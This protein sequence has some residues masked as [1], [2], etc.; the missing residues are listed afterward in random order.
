MFLGYVPILVCTCLSLTWTQVLYFYLARASPLGSSKEDN[1][2]AYRV[3]V[4]NMLYEDGTGRD[5]LLVSGLDSDKVLHPELRQLGDVVRDLHDYLLA[6]PWQKMEED[7]HFPGDLRLHPAHTAVVMRRILLAAMND[8]ALQDVLDIELC[9]THPRDPLIYRS[10]YYSNT[11]TDSSQS[12]SQSSS[13]NYSIASHTSGK[14]PRADKAAELPP[15]KRRKT[16]TKADSVE[17]LSQKIWKDHKWYSV[18]PRK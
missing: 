13:T 12:S 3:F 1:P 7:S 9:T 8:P 6:V 17:G 10:L 2:S 18:T 16:E 5:K 4:E 14:R 11:D 15:A